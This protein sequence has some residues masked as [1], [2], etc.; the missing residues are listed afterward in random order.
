MYYIQYRTGF[1]VSVV[2]WIIPNVTTIS[3]ALI[4]LTS[5]HQF[6]DKMKVSDI[7]QVIVTIEITK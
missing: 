3:S 1:N 5:C 7:I 4:F 6:S 2:K